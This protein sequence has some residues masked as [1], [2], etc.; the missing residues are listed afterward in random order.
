MPASDLS[1]RMLGQYHLLEQIGVGG[2]AQVYRATDS[3][4]QQ[5]AVKILHPHLTADQ[6]FVDRFGREA[7]AAASLDHPHIIRLLGHGVEDGLSYLALELVEGPSLKSLLA[8]REG[9]LAAEEAVTLVCAVADAL[10][11]AHSR[12]VVHRDIKPANILLRGGRLDD[13]VLSDFGVARMVE[14][15]LDTAAG[16]LLGTPTYMAPEQG[17]G[18]PGDER[19]DIYAL[20][21]ILYEL[22]TGRPPFEADSPYALILRH[23]HTPPPP[24]RSLRPD[25]PPALE[26]VLLR[27]LA[28]EPAGRY[29]SAADFAAALRASLVKPAPTRRGLAYAL[30]GVGLLL[31][32]LLTWRLGWLWRA[33]GSAGGVVAARPTPAVL[34]LQ[35]GPAISRHLARS[36]YAR[37][38]DERGR[39]G[40]FAGAVDPRS[41]DLPPGVAPVAAADRVAHRHPEHLHRPLESRRQPVRHRGRPPHLARL[42]ADHR[43]L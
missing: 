12:G 38:A 19:S 6:G 13:P 20:G 7:F 25:L 32:L 30:A 37:P 26:A 22:L 16:S 9:P 21:V 15:T 42:G 10:A 8:G 5:V 23:I 34:T 2:M 17:Q 24:P 1:G 36:R 11:H 33:P 27:A 31:A 40:A 35:G 39:Q 14:A 18:Q 43:D 29:A 4:G 3:A 28:K 41:R